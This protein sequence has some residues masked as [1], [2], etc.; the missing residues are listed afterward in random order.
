M[1]IPLVNYLLSLCG[2]RENTR[3]LFTF[4]CSLPVELMASRGIGPR[5]KLDE[6]ASTLVLGV[7]KNG[8]GIK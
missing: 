1:E 7:A 8:G 6:V 3:Q 4:T 2:N 5:T